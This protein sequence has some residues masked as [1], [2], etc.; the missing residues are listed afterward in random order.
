MAISKNPK[1]K[2]KK[3][4]K[5][6]VFNKKADL[7]YTEHHLVYTKHHLVYTKHQLMYTKHHLMYADEKQKI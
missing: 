4:K 2:R 1:Y 5:V 3:S 7:A 6:F